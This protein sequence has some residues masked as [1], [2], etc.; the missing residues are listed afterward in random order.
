MAVASVLCSSALGVCLPFLAKNY[1]SC[2]D[3]D[4]EMYLLIKAFAAGVILATGFVHVLPDAYESL[5]SPCLGEKPWRV[6]PFTGFV[7]M[8]SAVATLMMEALATGYHK[9]SAMKKPQPLNGDDD[10]GEA[11]P[12]IDH[13]HVHDAGCGDHAHGSAFALES[14]STMTSSDVVR[15]RIVSQVL[16]FFHGW[17]LV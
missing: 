12:N 1:L 14:S 13:H 5:S 3:P 10:G 11:V 15:H 8:V 16:E 6:F 7:A 9:R 17:Y 2:L 4:K